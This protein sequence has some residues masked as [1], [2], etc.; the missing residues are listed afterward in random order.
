MKWQEQHKGK[1]VHELTEE[2]QTQGDVRFVC[3]GCSTIVQF[4]S[5]LEYVSDGDD[6]AEYQYCCD[7]AGMYS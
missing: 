6:C 1:Q 5:E 3:E 7:C 2:E 4:E